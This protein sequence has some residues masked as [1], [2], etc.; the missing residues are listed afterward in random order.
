MRDRLAGLGEHEASDLRDGLAAIAEGNLTRTL[1]TT[2]PA[3]ERGSRDEIGD[4]EEAV[5]A[6]RAD[7]A[8]SIDRYNA[9]RE[10]TSS[11]RRASSPRRPA[12]RRGS[13]PSSSGRRYANAGRKLRRRRLWPRR[14]CRARSTSK[15]ASSPE[16][17]KGS[18]ITW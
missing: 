6:T 16:G 5:E 12:V 10:Q 14:S 17:R 9:M 7:T 3:I 11:P 4:L 1:T 8:T 2:A 13:R 15:K 18:A